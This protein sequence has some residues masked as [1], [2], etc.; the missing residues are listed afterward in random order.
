MSN[1]Q[2]IAIMAAVIWAKGKVTQQEAVAEAKKLFA[3][4]LGL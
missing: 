4:A 3:E 2:V 1:V